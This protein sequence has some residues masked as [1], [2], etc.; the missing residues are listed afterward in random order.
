MINDAAAIRFLPILSRRCWASPVRSRHSARRL[1][2]RLGDRDDRDAACTASRILCC[3][4]V[5]IRFASLRSARA[6][7]ARTPADPRPRA[8]PQCSPSCR[9]AGGGPCRSTRRV[10]IRLSLSRAVA[11]RKRT[12]I[13]APCRVSCLPVSLRKP[14]S[15]NTRSADDRLPSARSRSIEPMS[16][17]QIPRELVSLS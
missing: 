17:P 4:A 13:S 9:Y 14:S 12:N 1:W 6:A 11:W 7:D 3:V 15:T 5:S 8:T 2:S 10:S 16:A